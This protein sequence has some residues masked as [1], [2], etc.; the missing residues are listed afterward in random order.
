MTISVHMFR[1][2][3]KEREAFFQEF[4][5]N[6]YLAGLYGWNVKTHHDGCWWGDRTRGHAYCQIEVFNDNLDIHYFDLAIRATSGYSC[7][8][9]IDLYITGTA[10]EY[11]HQRIV[12]VEY[13]ETSRWT[14]CDYWEG[15]VKLALHLENGLCIEMTYGDVDYDATSYEADEYAYRIVFEQNQSLMYCLDGIPQPL[16]LVPHG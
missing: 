15:F 10:S 16:F 3:P 6:N 5:L 13:E 8:T 11:A 12:K 1:E 14:K 9:D 2:N 4:F 7:G